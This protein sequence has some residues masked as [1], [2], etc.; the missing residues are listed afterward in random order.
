M[1]KVLNVFNCIKQG[2]K[3]V[4]DGV[5]KK[6]K[7]RGAIDRNAALL[8]DG[9]R[10]RGAEIIYRHVAYDAT[11][12]ENA[13]MAQR[14]VAL[15]EEHDAHYIIFGAEEDVLFFPYGECREVTEE[16]CPPD[17]PPCLFCDGPLTL[18]IEEGGVTAIGHCEKCDKDF[19]LALT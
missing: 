12:R 1:A 13:E 9:V 11:A 8:S 19:P 14:V 18:T 2:D 17:V 10:E 15:I 6:G 3:V 5:L 16:E 4:L 7:S